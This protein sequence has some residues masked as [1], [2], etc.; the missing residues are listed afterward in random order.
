MSKSSVKFIAGLAATALAL[1]AMITVDVGALGQNSNSSTTMQ[2]DNTNTNTGRRGRRGR[3]GRA[4]MPDNHNMGATDAETMTAT[5]GREIS[6]IAPPGMMQSQQEAAGMSTD[7][8]G[9]YAGTVSYSEHD[10]NG[11]GTLTIT[12][13][14][15]TLTV[16]SMTH[17]G[18]F[19][20]RTTGGYTTA[21]M[22][23]GPTEAG[24]TPTML[25][26]RVCKRGDNLSLKSVPG[27]MR[28]FS[29]KTR[30]SARGGR[31]DCCRCGRSDM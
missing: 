14:S 27:E 6:V 7:L 30:G 15:Y 5:P 25:S 26:L 11:E 21:A 2:E 1:V 12:G 9:T 19:L 10:M 3:R 17:S 13:E 22:E 8:S 18:R 29:F 20:A 23:L 31:G 4:A 16:G 24:Q 28:K